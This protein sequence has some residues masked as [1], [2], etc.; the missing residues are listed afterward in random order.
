MRKGQD[1]KG[2]S[3][4]LAKGGIIVFL[5]SYRRDWL[6]Y[7]LLAYFKGVFTD[8]LYKVKE[9]F[10]LVEKVAKIGLKIVFRVIGYKLG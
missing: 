3:I 6:L 7:A 10:I 4:Y 8:F 9:L 5:L 1:T 2:R